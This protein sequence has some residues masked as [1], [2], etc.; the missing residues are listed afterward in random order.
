MSRSYLK[1]VQHVS[2]GFALAIFTLAKPYARSAVSPNGACE[3]HIN[4]VPP[5]Q[6]SRLFDAVNLLSL[7]SH[8]P[9]GTGAN[10][11]ALAEQ[12]ALQ[13]SQ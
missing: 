12:L 3:V 13:Q 1:H 8:V 4:A 7:M 6:P 5:L 9:T 2:V 10:T 11:M